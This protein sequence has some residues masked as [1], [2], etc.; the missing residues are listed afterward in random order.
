MKLFFLSLLAMLGL[1][2]AVVAQEMSAGASV[3]IDDIQNLQPDL[4]AELGVD[5]EEY[6]GKAPEEILLI[7]VQEQM[8]KELH[9]LDTL[10]PDIPSLFFTP[11]QYELLRSAITGFDQNLDLAGLRTKAGDLFDALPDDADAFA[12]AREIA[13]DGVVYNG[14]DD[15][16]VWLNNQRLTPK[17][18]PTQVQ[19]II[20]HKDYVDLKWFDHQTKQLIPVRMRPS[21]RFNLDTRLFLPG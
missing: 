1:S 2:G 19:A 17:R 9:R 13:L 8:R 6:K 15:W 14:A 10:Q 5:S 11:P 12:S 4:A 16:I 7:K 3:A 18:L 21:Q 20:V